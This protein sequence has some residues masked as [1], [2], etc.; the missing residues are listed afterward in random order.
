M[1]LA[2][3]HTHTRLSPDSRA[4]LPEMA[5]AARGAG[6]DGLWVTDHCD[7]VDGEGAPIDC[8][9]W[10]AAFA[11]M[12][13]ALTAAG[14]L[15]LR[16]GLELGSAPYD[17]PTA[18]RI[19]AGAGDRLDFV[20]GSLHNWL[21]VRGNADF[22]FTDFTGDP[23]LCRETMENVL[24]S[25]WALVSRCPDCYDSLAHIDYPLRYMVRD[26]HDVSILDWEDRVRPILTEVARTDRALEV[27][28]CRGTDLEVWS[29]VLGWFKQC[30]GRF[31]TAGSDAHSPDTVGSGIAES[32]AMIEAAGLSY[33]V[34]RGRRPFVCQ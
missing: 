1:Y 6:L 7:L 18:R 22:Y 3:C 13:E 8:F 23:A 24:E 33:T 4:L 19:L 17:P 32:R 11:Q 10:G 20:L 31:V 21:G 28:T 9:D 16:L 34:F 27:N 15:E 5:R 26:G 25:T 12:D 29:T 30:G 2:D 14:G